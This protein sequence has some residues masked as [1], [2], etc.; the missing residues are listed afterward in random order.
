MLGNSGARLNIYHI[1]SQ[2]Y[3][4]HCPS[5]SPMT[6]YRSRL[7]CTSSQWT[8]EFWLLVSLAFPETQC[9]RS[10]TSMKFFKVPIKIPSL[11][12]R[13]VTNFAANNLWLR[14]LVFLTSMAL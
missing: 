12:K 5:V 9:F 7:D 6:S 4:V 13:I 2:N 11:C 1:P 10:L 8:C 3:V 14:F